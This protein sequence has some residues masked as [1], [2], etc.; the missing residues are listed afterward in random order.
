M[1]FGFFVSYMI[2]VENAMYSTIRSGLAKFDV[3]LL[4]EL[5]SC[6][7]YLLNESAELGLRRRGT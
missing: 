2:A 1:G 3:S 6:V 4:K 7:S 5:Q